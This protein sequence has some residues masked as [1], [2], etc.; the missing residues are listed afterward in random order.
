MASS[1]LTQPIIN[2]TGWGGILNVDI[3]LLNS[4]LSGQTP[5]VG[6]SVSGNI[7]CTGT[8]TAGSFS[9]LNGAYF[10]QSS[11]FGQPNGVAQLNASSLIPGSAISGNGIAAVTY[12]ATP[13]FNAALANAF[14]ITLTGNVTASTFVNGVSAAGPFIA[15]RITQDSVGGRTFAW[16]TNVRNAG[17]PNPAPNSISTQLCLLQSDGSLDAAA[18]IMY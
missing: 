13:S 6:L 9:G 2:S 8:I 3:A 11:Q 7:V 16:P 10:L 15:F 1:P 5:I 17:T 18:P 12:S 4:I 14:N